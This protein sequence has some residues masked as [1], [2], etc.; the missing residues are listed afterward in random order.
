MGPIRSKEEEKEEKEENFL[1]L[2]NDFSF[3]F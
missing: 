2:N 3:Q 1:E